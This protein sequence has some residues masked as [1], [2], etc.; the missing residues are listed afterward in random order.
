MGK[1]VLITIPGLQ[2]TVVLHTDSGDL[3]KL[4]PGIPLVEHFMSFRGWEEH[5]NL[6]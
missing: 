2:Q 5:N 4:Y 1:R 6:I 3:K